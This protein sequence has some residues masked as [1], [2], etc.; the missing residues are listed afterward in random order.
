M[1]TLELLAVAILCIPACLVVAHS[2]NTHGNNP[3]L[4]DIVDFGVDPDFVS[5]VPGSGSGGTASAFMC[6]S[7]AWNDCQE[8]I[9]GPFQTELGYCI[10]MYLCAYYEC[11]LCEG[12]AQTIC[13]G[14][15]Q[16]DLY[17]CYGI[18]LVILMERW[19]VEHDV[20]VELLRDMN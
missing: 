6:G 20:A 12:I 18:D 14:N 8:D 5:L 7:N 10:S 11:G 17:N 3:W 15:A 9:Y 4:Q 16:Y 2:N 1:K 13:I 19:G